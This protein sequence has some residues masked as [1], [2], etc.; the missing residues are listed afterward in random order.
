MGRFSEYKKEIFLILVIL[1]C[2]VFLIFQNLNT[3]TGNVTGGSI[4]TNVSVSKYLAVTFGANLASGIE[5]GKVVFLPAA[6]VNASHN[7]DGINNATTF[8]IA[9]SS[10]S[11]SAVDFCI[12]ADKGLT[13]PALD[14]IG[15]GNETYSNSTT[16]NLNFPSLSSET[17]LTTNYTKSSYGVGTG[18][19]VYWRFWLDVPVSQP[20]GEYNNTISFKGVTSGSV[21]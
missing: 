3:L 18:D 9:V 17:S 7:Y 1:L 4:P 20:S 10:D 19:S 14:V 16:T 6:N 5:F 12:K 11:N 21:C 8:Y 2:L 15:L 13:S